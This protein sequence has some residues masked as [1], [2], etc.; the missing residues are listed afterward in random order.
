M[1][2]YLQII[3]TGEDRSKFEEIYLNYRG[4]MFHVAYDIL[5]NQQD[6]EDTVHKAFVKIAEN[7]QNIAPPCPKTK[8]LAVVM[9]KNQ[10]IDLWRQRKKHP[11][12]ELEPEAGFRSFSAPGEEGLLAK[13]ILQLPEAQ[14]QVV[15]L[16]YHYGY[17]LREIAHMMGRTLAWAQKADQRAKKQ[18]EQL[19]RDGGGEL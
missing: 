7:I 10:A 6:A 12:T 17:S 9:V 4:L 16:K 18:L 1:L 15:L 2:V 3:E 5:R 13:C 8:G 19:Y 14:R 11:Q